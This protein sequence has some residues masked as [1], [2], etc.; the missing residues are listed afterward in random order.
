MAKPPAHQRVTITGTLSQV[1]GSGSDIFDFGFAMVAGKS[2]AAVAQALAPIVKAQWTGNGVGFY[3]T[4]R[5]TAV[6][7]ESIDATGKV[8]S[9]YNAAIDNGNPG[10]YSIQTPTFCSACITLETG[11]VDGH[12]RKVRGRFFPPA[13]FSTIVGSAVAP[14]D[15]DSYRDSWTYFL[16]LLQQ[17]GSPIAVASSTNAGIAPV[18]GIS[19]DNVVDSQRSRK[20]RVTRLRSSTAALRTS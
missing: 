2:D 20:N 1:S 14:V 4:A 16:G 11:V 3:N 12:G 13:M 10:L 5:P 18:S 9:S 6:I 17:A 19:V 8:A 7:V 15:R